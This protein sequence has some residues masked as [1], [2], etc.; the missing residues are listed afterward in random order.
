M[1][2]K[3]TRHEYPSRVATAARRAMAENGSA[4]RSSIISQMTG[5]ASERQYR[6]RARCPNNV[7][8]D[9][10]AISVDLEC[11]THWKRQA[12]S[13]YRATCRAKRKTTGEG[14][15]VEEEAGV[16]DMLNGRKWTFR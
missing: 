2:P 1:S 10:A 12:A 14:V 7:R 6:G 9:R 3:N 13:L 4:K 8:L 11:V 16:D 5:E 15:V